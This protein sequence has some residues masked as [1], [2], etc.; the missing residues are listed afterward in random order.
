[1][2]ENGVIFLVSIFTINEYYGEKTR[3]NLLLLGSL[4]ELSAIRI[5]GAKTK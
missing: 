3:W 5:I 2:T 1:M 4:A